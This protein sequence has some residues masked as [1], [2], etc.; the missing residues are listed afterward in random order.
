MWFEWKIM[1]TWIWILEVLRRLQWLSVKPVVLCPIACWNHWRV[2]RILTPGFY[3]PEIMRWHE[4]QLGCWELGVWKVP[5]AILMCSRVGNH[6]SAGCGQ[7]YFCATHATKWMK[8]ADQ[9]A[10]SNHNKL[11]S[12]QFSE[13]SMKF[14]PLIMI[15]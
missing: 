7:W 14:S 6:S 12:E 11:W 3:F 1:L 15:I 10:C 9:L 5:E 2:L 13:S 8:R 4:M